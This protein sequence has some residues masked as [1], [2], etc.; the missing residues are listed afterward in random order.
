MATV[1]F[2]HGARVGHYRYTP[3]MIAGLTD[4]QVKE[5][6]GVVPCPIEVVPLPAAPPPP[7]PNETLPPVTTAAEGRKTK[8]QP[9]WMRR[10]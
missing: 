3:G 5:L 1:R 7:P 8:P 2:I 9:P 10:K 6:Q 4:E